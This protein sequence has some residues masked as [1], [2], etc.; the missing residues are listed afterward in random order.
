MAWLQAVKNGGTNNILIIGIL[1]AAVLL[2]L[3]VLVGV[4]LRMRESTAPIRKPADRSRAAYGSPAPASRNQAVNM[5]FGFLEKENGER[6]PLGALPVTVGRSKKNPIM[7]DDGS[8]AELHARIYLDALENLL[9][10]EDANEGNGIL[11]VNGKPTCRNILSHND[12]ITVGKVKL[13]YYEATHAA[14]S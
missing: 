1:I 8:V 13:R 5:E 7:V 4:L 9:C 6:V 2:I 12:E 14:G 11:L 3:L 10:I